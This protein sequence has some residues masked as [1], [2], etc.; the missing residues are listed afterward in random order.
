VTSTDRHLTLV[1]TSPCKHCENLA[2]DGDGLCT[3][4]RA[5]SACSDLV[6]SVWDALEAFFDAWYQP[7][8]G[9]GQYYSDEPAPEFGLAYEKIL[10]AIDQTYG[11]P[12][13]W[14]SWRYNGG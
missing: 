9:T 11:G 10:D 2:D 13:S 8:D 4:C 5:Q 1:S 3:P 14:S 6:E 7:H 12:R